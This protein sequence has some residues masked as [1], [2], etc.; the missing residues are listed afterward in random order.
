MAMAR[1]YRGV[2]AAPAVAPFADLLEAHVEHRDQE[3]AD[4]ARLDPGLDPVAVDPAVGAAE[5]GHIVVELDLEL[6][7]I[8][9][10]EDVA[11]CD[12]APFGDEGWRAQTAVALGL[13]SALRRQGR[14]GKGGE[15]L[16]NLT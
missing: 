14:P 11:G 8:E 1:G 3:D 6:R 15:R 4:R 5:G 13:E 7:G 9:L 16:E 12:G 10:Y 2:A